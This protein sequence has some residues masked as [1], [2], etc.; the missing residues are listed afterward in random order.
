VTQVAERFRA[1]TL[2]E[3]GRSNYDVVIVGAG[4][5]GLS[6]ALVLAAAS[7]ATA[8]Y[9]LNHALAGQDAED[10]V[11]AVTAVGRGPGWAT[12]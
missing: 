5:A 1:E 9:V 7:G 2:D 12:G 11:A 4:T 3:D 8:A 6:A 10:E